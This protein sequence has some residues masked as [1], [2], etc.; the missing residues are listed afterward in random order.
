MSAAFLG[1]MSFAGGEVGLQLVDRAVDL[2]A[3][4]HPVELVQQ[5]AME[6]LANSIGLRVFGLGACGPAAAACHTT[7]ARRGQP[8]RA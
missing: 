3:E 5:G 8:V 2:F 1:R 6:T 4:C 7:I